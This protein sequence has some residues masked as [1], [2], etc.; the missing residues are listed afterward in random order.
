MP[1]YLS[2]IKPTFKK[3]AHF[4]LDS[5]STDKDQANSACD[6]I[7]KAIKSCNKIFIFI[8]SIKMNLRVERD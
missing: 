3:S 6:V 5:V 2:K 1:H 8:Y 4:S 7:F